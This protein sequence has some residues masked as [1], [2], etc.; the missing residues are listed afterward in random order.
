MDA[1]GLN[2]AL[3]AMSLSSIPQIALS[4]LPSTPPFP[5]ACALPSTV[6]AS[7]S[8]AREQPTSQEPQ[9]A[10]LPSQ[11]NNELL[12]AVVMSTPSTALDYYVRAF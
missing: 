1:G 4:A 10:E 9:S 6:P 11:A 7:V 3:S 8:V 12:A 5:R 2:M